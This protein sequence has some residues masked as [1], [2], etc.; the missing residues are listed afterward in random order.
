MKKRYLEWRSGEI[1]ANPRWKKELPGYDAI[2]H[3]FGWL[4]HGVSCSHRLSAERGRS[5]QTVT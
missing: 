3:R 1:A 2:Y 5:D 4:A